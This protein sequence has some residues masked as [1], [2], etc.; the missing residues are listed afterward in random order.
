MASTRFQDTYRAR[1][2]G[3]LG[4]DMVKLRFGNA[5]MA[6]YRRL[7]ELGFRHVPSPIECGSD[8]NS[9]DPETTGTASGAGGAGCVPRRRGHTRPGRVLGNR[10]LREDVG[11]DSSSAF[12]G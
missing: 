4:D 10:K 12:V 9:S 6:L 5:T 1:L 8:S 3:T 11:T 2:A 7:L